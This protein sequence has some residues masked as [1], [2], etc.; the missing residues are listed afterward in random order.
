MVNILCIG[1]SDAPWHQ[2]DEYQIELK[3][4]LK[5]IPGN[6]HYTEDLDAFRADNIR[7]FKLIICCVSERQLKP[8]Q[9]SG[10]LTAISGINPQ[11]TGEPKSF[12]GFHC[13]A[14]AFSESSAYQRMLGA[15]FLAH[16][17]MRD[18]IE[19][20]ILRPD[21]P[22]CSGIDSFSLIDELYLFE[23]YGTFTTLF[24]SRYG[25]FNCPLGW[26]KQYGMGKVCY[27]AFGHGREQLQEPV[28]REIMMNMG[29]WSLSN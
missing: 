28:V 20:E 19:V 21:H 6:V 4:I 27:S 12:F 24:Q 8:E 16:P 10:L 22:V 13:A 26:V 18:T 23:T 29:L 9:E 7:D 2:F 1:G 25:E 5:D 15:R 17:P 3:E 11:V 14:T